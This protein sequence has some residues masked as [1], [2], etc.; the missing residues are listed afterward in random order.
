MTT[1]SLAQ[2]K[3]LKVG[4]NEMRVNDSKI[5]VRSNY[6]VFLY[7]VSRMLYISL[8]FFLACVT[9]RCALFLICYS[10]P[11]EFLSLP[12]Q[13]VTKWSIIMCFL[14]WTIVFI[15]KHKETSR[16]SSLAAL[17]GFPA[18]QIGTNRYFCV[19][20]PLNTNQSIDHRSSVSFAGMIWYSV[21]IGM[22]V[23]CVR[24]W[25]H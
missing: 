8:F 14:C 4:M 10:Q 1:F 11:P 3:K 17:T 25:R 22:L 2:V 23:G 20:V 5:S 24:F 19:D 6:E 9:R 16:W 12:G 15:N 21:Y 13:P 18:W 7:I